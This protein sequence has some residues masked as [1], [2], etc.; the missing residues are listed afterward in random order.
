MKISI[1]VANELFSSGSYPQ[2]EACYQ[3]L[4]NKYQSDGYPQS[5]VSH[6]TKQLQK[7]KKI[8]AQALPNE[9]PSRPRSHQDEHETAIPSSMDTSV[10]ATKPRR[11]CVYTDSR[12]F[13]KHKGFTGSMFW[14]KLAGQYQVDSFVQP[15]KWTTL[16]DFIGLLA[17]GVIDPDNYDFIIV[18]AGIVDFSPRPNS[19]LFNGLCT[20]GK[21]S[22]MHIAPGK[23]YSYARRVND[24]S[25]Y[26]EYLTGDMTTCTKWHK[27]EGFDVF[28]SGERTSN[29]YPPEVAA[30]AG[31]YL[32]RIDKLIFIDSCQILPDWD[33]DFSKGRPRNINAVLRHYDE[34]LTAKLAH[35]ILLSRW[36]PEEV[37]RFTIDNLHLTQEG[38][39]ELYQQLTKKVESLTSDPGNKEAEVSRLRNVIV[40]A[41]DSR[42]FSSLLLLIRSA[43]EHSAH[44]LDHIAVFDLGLEAAQINM[45]NGIKKVCVFS[46]SL[47]DKAVLQALH[48]DFFDPCTYGFKVY[49]LAKFHQS[50]CIA[51]GDQINCLYID[52]GIKINRDISSIFE[53]ISA[54]GVFCVDHND[55]HDYYGSEAFMLL[56]ILSPHLYEKKNGLQFD[57]LADDQLIKPYIKAGFFGYRLNGP[58]QDLIDEHYKLCT[59]TDVLVQP[60]RITDRHEQMWYRNNTKVGAVCTRLGV[61]FSSLNYINGRQDQTCLSYLVIKAGI[62]IKNSRSYNF[63]ESTNTTKE[64][65]LNAFKIRFNENYHLFERD[66]LETLSGLSIDTSK[67][68]PEEVVETYVKTMWDR[69]EKAERLTT[70]IQLPRSTD[71]Y[72]ALTSL[73]RGTRARRDEWKYSGRLLNHYRNRNDRD[74]FVLLGNGPSLADVD[75]NSLGNFSTFGL[76]AA[77]RAYERVGFWP[78][79]FGC[80]DSLVCSHHAK[81]FERLIQESPI[82]RF[83]FINF[84]DKRR[85]IFNDPAI[86]HHPKFTNIDFVARTPPEKGVDD[87]L[88]TSFQPFVDMLTSGTNS[89]QCALLMG[90]RKIIILGCDANYVEVVDGAKQEANRNKL[91]MEKTPEINP[92]YWFS[93]YQQEGDKFN[94]P[95]LAG[96][97][98]PAWGRLAKTIDT[99]GV[100]AEIIN[101]SAISKINDFK[102]MPLDDAIRYFQGY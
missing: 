78:R 102:K 53:L 74:I 27:E 98:L 39:D 32:S 92:N 75:L 33:G 14:E 77:Y 71:G 41:S 44:S 70:A 1:K 43:L 100:N 36:S 7:I 2:A 79:Y 87:I 35:K 73:H 6:C 52:A 99:L 67:L 4:L 5:L 88:A 34:I 18:W 80:F 25:R 11:L 51:S 55:C 46:Y 82:E 66:I 65:W 37:K 26:V 28:F 49:A 57:L 48:F 38:S 20:P 89:L 21:P 22:L 30:I 81:S 59:L 56:H 86:L 24:K 31:E 47:E 54:E 23:I 64:K 63:T 29:L 84:N 58:Y 90:F 97:Q 61:R 15:F 40:T 13:H 19:Q 96:C 10:I 3:Q 91:V 83:F 68:R 62:S 8:G 42:F 50:M 9:R 60:K 85:P 69:H 72:S 101:C 76:N 93:D 45:L 17:D 94:L 12:G 95:N 16:L